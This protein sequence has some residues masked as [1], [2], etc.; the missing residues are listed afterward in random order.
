M[1]ENIYNPQKLTEELQAAG[2]PVA[3]VSSTGRIDYSRVLTASEIKVSESVIEAHYQAP[4]TKDLR[5]QAYKDAGI[6]PEILIY[7]LWDQ[8]IKSDSSAVTV[9]KE[10]IEAIDCGIN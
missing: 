8:I 10:K 6:T 7:A 5:I 4:L 9:L 2:L 1:T 3:G